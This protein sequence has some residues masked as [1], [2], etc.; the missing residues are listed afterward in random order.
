MDWLVG[1]GSST[2]MPLQ[3]LYRIEGGTDASQSARDDLDGYRQ[4]RPVLI[5][6]HAY[7]QT[8]LDALGYFADCALIYL[9]RG[10]EWKDEYTRLILRLVDYTI[11]HWREP[12]NCI[13]ELD[14][15]QHY[16]S[17]KVMAWVTLERACAIVERIGHEA[18]THRWRAEM[19]QIRVA[20]TQHG[21]S[22]RL[23]A[24][25][26][27]YESDRALDAAALLIPI[28]RFLPADDPRVST[29]MDVIAT[30]FAR[31]KLVYRFES[32]KA[33]RRPFEAAAG[34]IRG[35]FPAVHLLAGGCSRDARPTRTRRGD[36]RRGRGRRGPARVVC[37]G[38]RAALQDI[39]RQYA[40]PI[41]ARRIPARCLQDCES[42][43]LQ[44][45]AMMVGQAAARLER[46][47]T[48]KS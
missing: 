10:G 1:L 14:R 34:R 43:P 13:W 18:D 30:E 6:N 15:K 36:P 26:Q 44:G 42:A 24:F 23:Q 17:S 47:I 31:G 27:R 11:A 48:S 3:V 7:R 39:S 35:R 19:E 45:A 40:A 20:V 9:Q 12:D 33:C 37:R 32:G 4:S 25:R 2:A 38:H 41:L 5:G 21:W 28:M 29:T 22:E 16:V 8:Q 46:L